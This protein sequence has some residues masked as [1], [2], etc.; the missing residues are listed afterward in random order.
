MNLGHTFAHAIEVE[1]KH[2]I[3]HGQA[4]IAGLSCALHLSNKMNLLSDKNL[5]KYFSLIIS[6]VDDVKIEKYNTSKL[7]EIM[8][9]DKKNKEDKIKFVLLSNAG[10]IIIDIEASQENVFYALS[11]GLQYFVN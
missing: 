9:R 3:K 5:E 8:R 2:K 4:V 10:N 11:N 6:F 7:Y 1:Q